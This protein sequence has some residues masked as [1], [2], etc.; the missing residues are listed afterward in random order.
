MLKR[1][2]GIIDFKERIFNFFITQYMIFICLQNKI[3]VFE[4]FSLQFIHKITRVD[5]DD[6]LIS[7][8]EKYDKNTKIIE[9]AYIPTIYNQ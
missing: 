3:D 1:T 2:I 5:Y 4:L 6:N 7:I 8:K 9:L